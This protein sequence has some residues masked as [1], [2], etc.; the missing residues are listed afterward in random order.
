MLKLG[1]ECF[2][3]H[4][5]CVQAVIIGHDG[6]EGSRLCK[7]TLPL[8][9]AGLGI[10]QCSGGTSNT[11]CIRLQERICIQKLTLQLSTQLRLLLL[12]GGL[13]A[14]LI[15]GGKLGLQYGFCG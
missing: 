6:L 1:L 10:G 2:D 4:Q 8:F 11:G 12:R 5:A 15:E 13:C 7:E 14:G 3:L 9:T